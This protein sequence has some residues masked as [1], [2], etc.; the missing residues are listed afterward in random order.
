M[1]SL[2]VDD[3]NLCPR[4]EE[5]FQLEML[6]GEIVLLH[7]AR[8]IIIHGNQTSAILWQLCDGTRTVGEIVE[9]LSAAYPD[10]ADEIQADVPAAI[11]MLTQHGA[12]TVK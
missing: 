9:L 7:P 10:A 6:N 4:H 8:S 2:P 3:L 11:Q 12:L 1:L 5:G